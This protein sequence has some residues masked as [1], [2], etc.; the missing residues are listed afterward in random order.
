MQLA[1]D[2]LRLEILLLR[3]WRLFENFTCI[4][5]NILQTICNVAVLGLLFSAIDT[6]WNGCCFCYPV[7][8][9]EFLL[10]YYDDN[11]SSVIITWATNK[12][13][14]ISTFLHLFHDAAKS[15]YQTTAQFQVLVQS[16]NHLWPHFALFCIIA[17]SA[18]RPDSSRNRIYGMWNG[19]EAGKIRVGKNQRAL[20]CVVSVLIS[21]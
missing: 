7:K 12:M 17:T 18:Q 15:I 9:C 19:G 14:D 1:S 20:F 6:F 4:F 8:K 13:I 11:K 21:W 5:S 10:G 2:E 3:K 16:K